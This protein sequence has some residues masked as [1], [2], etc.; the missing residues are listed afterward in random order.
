MTIYKHKGFS[1]GSLEYEWLS[2]EKSAEACDPYPGRYENV[3]FTTEVASSFEASEFVGR[4]AEVA[5]RYL[6]ST[7]WYV[8]REMDSGEP[9]PADVKQKRAEARLKI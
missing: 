5:Q 3:T 7:D 6:K 4:D 9:M 1:N 2:S 8:I